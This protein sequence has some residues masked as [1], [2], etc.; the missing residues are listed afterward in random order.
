MEIY[1][2]DL[3]PNLNI[4]DLRDMI[5]YKNGH[6]ISAINI[7]Y[8]ILLSNP[9]RFLNKNSTYYFYCKSGVR[10]KKATELLSILGYKVINVKD[11]YKE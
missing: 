7:P 11:G 4:I 9:S 8:N 2:K 3:R 6:Y 1:Y 5:D 10:S